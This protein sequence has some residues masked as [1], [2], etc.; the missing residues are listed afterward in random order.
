MKNNIYRNTNKHTEVALLDVQKY[1]SVPSN[2]SM[3][4]VLN[5]K[6]SIV[7]TNGVISKLYRM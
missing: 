1:T 4:I 7:C 5:Q 6:F 3:G 2:I